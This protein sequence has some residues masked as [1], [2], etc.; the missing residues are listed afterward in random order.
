MTLYYQV[1][2]KVALL[3]AKFA[4]KTFL[5]DVSVIP[6]GHFKFH[7]LEKNADILGGTWGYFF[8]GMVPGTQFHHQNT[9]AKEW[10]R[11]QDTQLHYNFIMISCWISIIF[12][13]L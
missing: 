2:N 9:L 4:Q 5:I 1:H 13:W 11:N 7:P 12:D 8:L 10:S 6:G 3:L